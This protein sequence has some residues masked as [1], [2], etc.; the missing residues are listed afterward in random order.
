M[1]IPKIIHY[2]WLSDAP[3][4]KLQEQCFASWQK[5]FPDY[6]FRLWD[7]NSEV[8][9]VPFVK[10]MMK[11]KKWAFASDYIRLYALY[12]Y[13]GIYLD[14][15]VMVLKSFDALLNNSCFV[16]REDETTLACHAIGTEKNNAFIYACLSY[17]NTSKKLKF[18]PPPT[19]PRVV[20][21]IA[22]RYGLKAQDKEIEMLHDGIIVY[23][24]VY[25]SPLHYTKRL[26]KDG[27]K[28]IQPESYCI[29][30]WQHNWSWLNSKS[31]FEKIKN[32]PWLFMNFKDWKFILK[33]YL[34][35]S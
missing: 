20:T 11:H 7:A 26:E 12:N 34:K 6:T 14:L 13:G 16:G 4:G 28:Y 18:S 23:P 21:K 17:Y 32:L 19:I 27:I 24:S 5:Y 30:F 35:W 10:K 1:A 2:C 8:V 22:K 31:K 25:F 9:R 15:D 3:W 33:K 29:H